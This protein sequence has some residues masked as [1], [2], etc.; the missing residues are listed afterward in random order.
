[1]KTNIVK[2][3]YICKTKNC[4]VNTENMRKRET[5]PYIP[6]SIFYFMGKPKSCKEMN[7]IFILIKFLLE[8]NENH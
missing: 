2:Y 6:N 3:M 5:G 1:M 4:I 8:I 7:T